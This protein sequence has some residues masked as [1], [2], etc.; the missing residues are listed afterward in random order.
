MKLPVK[1]SNAALCACVISVDT[2]NVFFFLSVM[3]GRGLRFTV[4]EVT[5]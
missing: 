3:L 2:G 1:L 5:E 4:A